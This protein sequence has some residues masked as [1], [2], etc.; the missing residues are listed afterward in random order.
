VTKSGRN[1]KTRKDLFDN[2]EF[3]EEDTENASNSDKIKGLT[4][5]W[6]L[7]QSL[8]CF[9]EETKK[10]TIAELTQLHQMSV[11]QPINR[12]SMTR[13]ELIGTMNTLTFIKRKRCGRIKARICA[14][15]RPQKSLFQ[16]WESSS[17][18]A[19]TESVLINSVIDAYKQRVVG[20][21]DIP[22][23]FLHAGQT[24]LTYIKMTGEAAG[25]LIEVSP[26]TY[27]NTQS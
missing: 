2:Y 20:V 22:G 7:K 24:D 21:Y 25:L 15:G 1:V 23:A 5:Q 18:T 14:D 26:N 13:Q 19:R 12:L 3:L 17:P 10:A 9:P 27:K 11:F 6:S 8:R 4:T 16:K